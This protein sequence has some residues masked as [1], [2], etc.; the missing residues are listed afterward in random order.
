MYQNEVSL[1]LF[2]TPPSSPCFRASADKTGLFPQA[3][4]RWE[5]AVLSANLLE[6]LGNYFMKNK[7]HLNS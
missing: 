4:A 1:A 2:P 6:P 7:E 5:H 3:G